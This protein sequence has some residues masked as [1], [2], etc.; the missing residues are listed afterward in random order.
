[1]LVTIIQVKISLHLCMNIA[2][3]SNKT[4]GRRLLSSSTLV[5]VQQF[6]SHSQTHKHD[7]VT[8]SAEKKPPKQI[9]SE[10]FEKKLPRK[11]GKENLVV[12]FIMMEILKR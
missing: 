9:R 11:S 3:F 8:L 1:M 7:N 2:I 12:R 6:F 10:F 5:Q 4:L